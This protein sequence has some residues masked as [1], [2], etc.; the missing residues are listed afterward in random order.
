MQDRDP[1]FDNE[2]VQV[3]LPEGAAPVVVVCEHASNCFPDEFQNLGLSDDVRQSHVAWDPGALPL[4]Q[5][6]AASL[7]ATLVEGRASRLLF[8]CNRPPEAP[9]A[10]PAR[11]EVHDIPGNQTLSEA[12]RADRVRRFHDPFNLAT[13]LLLDQQDP[14]LMVT[15]HSFTPNYRGQLRDVEI[16]ILHD[17][18]SRFADAMLS[19]AG[20]HTNMIV[21]R[22]DPYGPEHG[23]THT[24]KTHAQSR[25]MLNVMI[26]VRNDLLETADQQ[27]AIAQMLSDWIQAAHAALPEGGAT[28]HA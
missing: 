24:L 2:A 14:T 27:V 11:S 17:S 8:D 7:S 1:I 26:E 9:D 28:C 13:E 6:L 22:N 19:R 23:V 4:A 15:V 3:T 25:G 21:R 12:D 10:M 18:D 16:G 5:H 20:Q